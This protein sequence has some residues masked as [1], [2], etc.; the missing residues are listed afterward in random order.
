MQQQIRCASCRLDNTMHYRNHTNLHLCSDCK[1][2]R[3]QVI[4]SGCIKS[5]VNTVF[6]VGVEML[7]HCIITPKTGRANNYQPLDSSTAMSDVDA[8]LKA[9]LSTTLT[10]PSDQSLGLECCVKAPAVM[11]CIFASA[12]CD[13]HRVIVIM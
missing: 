7:N 10:F 4:W 11:H 13:M 8:A 1:I 2:V 5:R 6:I 12:A 9:T 3:C